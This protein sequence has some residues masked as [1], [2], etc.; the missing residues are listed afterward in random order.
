MRAAVWLALRRAI[1]NVD[2]VGIVRVYRAWGGGIGISLGVYWL[3]LALTWPAAHNPAAT[4][5][6]G[7][8]AIP[9]H[10]TVD[11]GGIQIGLLLVY[12]VNYVALEI[13]TL[14]PCRLLDGWP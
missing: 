5:L 3:A 14:E 2:D 11:P 13:W 10:P 4:T 1:P 7:R 12:W 6:L 9:M 8:F